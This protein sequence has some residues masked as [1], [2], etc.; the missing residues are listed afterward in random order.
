MKKVT[1]ALTTSLALSGAAFAAFPAQ[2]ADNATVY[3]LHAVPEATVD[4]WAN[5]KPLLTDFTPATLTK[6]L[7]LPAGDYDLKVVPAGAAADAPAIIEANDVT[8]PAGANITVVAHLDDKGTPALTP[9]V[10][11][12]AKIE[13]GKARL[14]VRHV[15]KAP[16][17]DVRANTN[18]AFPNLSNP[19]STEADLAAGTITADVVLAGTDT[20]ALGP[21]ELTLKEGTNTVVYAWGDADKSLKLATQTLTGMHSHPGHVPSGTGGQAA[22]QSNATT[23]GATG[24]GLASLVVA[25]LVVA[26]RRAIAATR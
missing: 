16:V 3:V 11:N 1:L 10:N 6:G 21:A 4:V 19:Q 13:A 25:G 23:L 18:V 14:T 2:A 17:V 22:D 20:V 7:S 15:A 12:T 26:R 24:L 9:Y 8:V 5:G